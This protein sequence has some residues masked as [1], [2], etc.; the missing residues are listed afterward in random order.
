[1]PLPVPLNRLDRTMSRREAKRQLGLPESAVVLFS[2]ASAYKYEPILGERSFT[3]VLTPI[4][5]QHENVW[6]LVVGPSFQGQWE[7]AS[8]ETD[9]RVRAYGSRGDAAVFYQAA[10]IYLDPFPFASTTSF[11]EAGSYALPLVSF[12][13]FTD[14]TLVLCADSP[15]LEGTMIRARNLDDYCDAIKRLI[16]NTEARS[17]LGRRTRELI[18]QAHV[19]LGWNEALESV[20]SRCSA[21]E[22]MKHGVTA[23]DVS[24]ADSLDI[25]LV[26]I[27]EK[28]GMSRDINQ[29]VRDDAGLLPMSERLKLWM[30]RPH[31]HL[32]LLPRFMTSAWTRTALRQRLSW[33]KRRISQDALVP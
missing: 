9:G 15:E 24:R 16:Q 33:K 11:L 19:G 8:H 10:D 17:K 4:I 7:K 25:R 21:I 3:D 18:Q 30:S 28:A 5:K 14:D 22:P 12:S 26:S 13:P 32:G 6:L 2:I 31:R 29:I 23:I 20:Y 27:F 1:V